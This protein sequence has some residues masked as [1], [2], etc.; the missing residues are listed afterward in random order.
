MRSYRP[1]SCTFDCFLLVGCRSWALRQAA[2]F[3]LNAQICAVNS[4][5]LGQAPAALDVASL[6]V[7]SQGTVYLYGGSTLSGLSNELFQ[8]DP[9]ENTWEQ[10]DNNGTSA[11]DK[12][13]F[14][15]L[16]TAPDGSLYLYGGYNAE[17]NSKCAFSLFGCPYRTGRTL[18]T[19]AIMK[20]K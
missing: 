19:Q 9:L 2:F 4:L 12:L 7:T 5:T 13:I 15:T 8:F 20:S 14:A 18:R 1:C 6:T 17:I 11:P 3:F 10:L 16:W